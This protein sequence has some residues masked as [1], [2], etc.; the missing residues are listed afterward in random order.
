MNNLHFEIQ[1]AVLQHNVAQQ[2][3]Q[4]HMDWANQVHMDNALRFQNQQSTRKVKPADFG[5]I[6]EVA[7]D[8]EFM[9]EYNAINA[10]ID[11]V[12]AL[13]EAKRKHN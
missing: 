13:I 12:A 4:Q 9:A 7:V 11:R 10:E 1:M 3:H 6:E 5:R 8:P 2:S